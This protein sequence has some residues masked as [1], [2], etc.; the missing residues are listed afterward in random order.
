MKFTSRRSRTIAGVCSR[1]SLMC[2]RSAADAAPSTICPS[3][4]ITVMSPTVRLWNDSAMVAPCASGRA[5]RS[6]AS[7][8][9]LVCRSDC[10]FSLLISAF[11]LDR[12]TCAW[13][14]LLITRDAVTLT[15]GARRPWDR[16]GKRAWPDRSRPRAPRSA[17]SSPPSPAPEDR[18]ASSRRGMTR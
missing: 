15:R 1:T 13:G 8:G 11:A 7:T 6:P 14:S 4:L 3:H 9:Q 10:S 18:L 12:P 17:E 16:V 2:C 5:A